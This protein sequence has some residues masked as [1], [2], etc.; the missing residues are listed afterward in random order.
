LARIRCSRNQIKRR[1]AGAALADTLRSAAHAAAAI[2][3]AQPGAVA[4]RGRR[5]EARSLASEIRG[6]LPSL[7]AWRRWPKRS[8]LAHVV[9]Y[10]QATR[11]TVS[12]D[13]ERRGGRRASSGE[14]RWKYDTVFSL[15]RWAQPG[16]LATLNAWR[17]SAAV[18]A[19]L[20]RAHVPRVL[21][22]CALRRA[23]AAR[24]HF[25]RHTRLFSLVFSA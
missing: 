3:S 19:Y 23:A 16:A 7:K 22:I 11:G 9:A 20:R 12:R 1:C 8:Q 18:S 25:W 5:R 14:T 13:R 4:Q 10:H 15:Q 6:D 21:W 24:L 2:R 17:F